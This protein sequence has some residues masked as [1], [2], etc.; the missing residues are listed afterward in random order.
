MTLF[1]QSGKEILR[2]KLHGLC[3]VKFWLFQESAAA[4]DDKKKIDK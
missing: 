4:E 1:S 3:T 2:S